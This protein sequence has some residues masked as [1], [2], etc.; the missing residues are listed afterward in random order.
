MRRNA[1]LITML[2]T[3]IGVA[4]LALFFHLRSRTA[5]LEAFHDFDTELPAWAA[6]GLS[7]WFLPAALGFAAACSLAGLAA[8]LRRT[9]RAFLVG[10]GLLVAA[11]ALIFAVTVGFLAI[12]QPAGSAAAG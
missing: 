11:G 1:A 6:V 12:F 9:Q 2:V 5:I 8:P 4:A 7:S 3:E 10:L